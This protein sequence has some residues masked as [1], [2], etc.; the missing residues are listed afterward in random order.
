[1]QLLNYKIILCNVQSICV[2][3]LL[4]AQYIFNSFK[5]NI[6]IFINLHGVENQLI[7]FRLVDSFILI[8]AF[9]NFKCAINK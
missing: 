1:M 7:G 2:E 3:F 5:F 9:F 8:V 4:C 6:V